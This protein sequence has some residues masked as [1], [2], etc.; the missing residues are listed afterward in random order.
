MR[1]VVLGYIVRGPLGGM[2]WHHLQ[3]VLCLK[4]MG[5]KVLFLEDS[6]NFESCY[7]PETFETTANPDFGLRYIEEVFNAFDLKDQWAYYDNFTNTWYGSGKS[8]VL[9][10][11]KDADLVINISAVNPVREWWANIPIRVM[12]DTDPC[13][14]QIK[15]LQSPEDFAAAKIHT[16]FFSFGENFGRDDCRI[17][18]DG[19]PWKSTRQPV[20]LPAWDITKAEPERSWTTVMQWDSYSEKE[21]GGHCYGMKSASFREYFHLP[22]MLTN[23]TFELALGNKTAPAE[24][25]VNAGWKLVPPQIPT[26]T[27]QSFQKY[28]QESKGEWSIAK[29]GY[30]TSNSGWFSERSAGYLASGRPVVLQDTGFSR[31]IETGRGLFSFNNLEEA[32]E[33]INKVNENYLKHCGYARE[34]VEGYFNGSLVLDSLIKQLN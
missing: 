24:E 10:F 11:C 31:V 3:Y 2:I 26:K 32:V 7:N 18:L 34:V 27:A 12:I 15:N 28:I 16:H 4:Q 19:F 9:Q 29:H 21:F 25:L 8:I 5:H 33:S 20:F 17:P 6:D 30:V 1:I 23:E 14:T 13:F 22:S